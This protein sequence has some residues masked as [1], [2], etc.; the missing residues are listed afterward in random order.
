MIGLEERD[1]NRE[2][3]KWQEKDS[4]VLKKK[5]I[6]KIVISWR[7]KDGVIG[8]EGKETLWLVLNEERHCDWFWRKKDICD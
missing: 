3:L 1:T 2:S 7:K 6:V 5:K 8:L 4:I